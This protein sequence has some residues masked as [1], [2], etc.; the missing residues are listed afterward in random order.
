MPISGKPI[1]AEDYG[2]YGDTAAIQAAIDLSAVGSATVQQGVRVEIGPGIWTG[3]PITTRGKPLTL[4]GTAGQ[5][6]TTIRCSNASIGDMITVDATSHLEGFVVDCAPSVT[7]AMRTGAGIKVQPG[8]DI[9]RISDVNCIGHH[10]GIYNLAHAP[11]HVRCM[12]SNNYWHGFAYGDNIHGQ[13]EVDSDHCQSNNNG[14][15]GQGDGF[16]VIGQAAG[17]FFKSRP[18]SVGNHGNG[19]RFINPQPDI[20]KAARYVYIDCPEISVSGGYGIRCDGNVLGGIFEVDGG[21][22]EAG[23][24]LGAAYFS[25]IAGLIWRGCHVIGNAGIG[26]LLDCDGAIVSGSFMA[27]NAMNIRLGANSRNIVLSGIADTATQ[28]GVGANGLFADTGSG[29]FTATG[30][31]F[32]AQTTPWGG[33]IHPSSIIRGCRGI[34]DMN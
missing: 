2:T 27:G 23:P 1:Q 33:A 18:T 28:F 5:R 22:I 3:A 19:F 16:L 31:D 29:P 14:H 30:V 32:K 12:N 8:A 13:N 11:Q 15:D 24:G 20:L 26:L 7:P 17:V 25:G 21:M 6:Q 34:A 9:T 4:V 10:T